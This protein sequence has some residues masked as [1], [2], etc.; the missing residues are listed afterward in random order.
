MKARF[1]CKDRRNREIDQV[2]RVRNILICL[3][4]LPLSLGIENNQYSE[5]RNSD[6]NDY[7]M[8]QITALR[9]RRPIGG[10][11]HSTHSPATNK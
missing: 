3:T 7:C 5:R 1:R 4:P 8:I 10:L 9:T 11:Y 6:G 2:D